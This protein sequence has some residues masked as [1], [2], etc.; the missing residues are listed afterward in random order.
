[1]PSYFICFYSVLKKHLVLKGNFTVKLLI[2]IILLN[3]PPIVA[4]NNIPGGLE[5]GSQTETAL[6][7][8]AVQLQQQFGSKQDQGGCFIYL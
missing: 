2:K 8:L 5:S 3:Q 6:G 1:M 4:E 7:V